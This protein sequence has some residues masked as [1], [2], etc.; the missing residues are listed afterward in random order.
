MSISI[1]N[2]YMIPFVDGSEDYIT[3][4]PCS[5]KVYFSFRVFKTVFFYL[6]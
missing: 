1:W 4:I 6:V 3:K 5:S 2:K